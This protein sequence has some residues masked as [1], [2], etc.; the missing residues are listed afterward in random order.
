MCQDYSTEYNSCGLVISDISLTEKMKIEYF[1]DNFDKI[2]QKNLENA[3][4]GGTKIPDVDTIKDALMYLNEATMAIG[5]AQYE[6]ES[7]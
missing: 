5:N 4:N 2:S 6:I 3:V 1:L 7:I